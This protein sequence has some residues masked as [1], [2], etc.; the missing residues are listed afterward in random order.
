MDETQRRSSPLRGRIR[1][2]SPYERIKA[3]IIDGTFAPGTPLVEVAVAQWAGVS[4]TP[5]REAL[6]RLEHDG[7]VQRTDQGLVVRTRS[8]EEI[9]DIYDLRIAIEAKAARTAA[10]RHTQFDGIRL[11]RLLQ[12]ADGV[13]AENEVA[14]VRH[15]RD[16]HR[17]IWEMSHNQSIVDLLQRLDLHLL[18]YPATTL[19]YPDRWKQ[20]L[21]EHRRLAAAI[22][23]RE[24]DK[25]GE[26]AT[27]H[28][29]AARD[30]RLRL[31]ERDLA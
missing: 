20:A 24:V 4:R 27:A 23:G 2:Q 14:M 15:N 30:I 22:L 12:E 21:D 8:P 9:L 29:T 18:R 31:F 25:A 6:T 19:S 16:F 5:V 26:I 11:E 7:L 13:D 3:A 17:A 1:K 28:F 10:E